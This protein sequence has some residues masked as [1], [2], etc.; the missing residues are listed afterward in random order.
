M[1]RQKDASLTVGAAYTRYR[2]LCDDLHERPLTRAEFKDIVKEAVAEVYQVR[3]RHDVI[4][5]ATNKM[6][7]GWR[8]VALVSGNEGFQ[9]N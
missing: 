5:G 6:T 4:D 3:L 7:H 9:L 1:V 8:G 2:G